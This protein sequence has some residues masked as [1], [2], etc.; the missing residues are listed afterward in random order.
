MGIGS[1]RQIGGT[2]TAAYRS[3]ARHVGWDWFDTYDGGEWR[4]RRVAAPATV[5]TASAKAAPKPVAADGGAP[6]G[7]PLVPVLRPG[8]PGIAPA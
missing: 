8:E 2:V 5:V 3:V 1:V 4:R 7:R 6:A